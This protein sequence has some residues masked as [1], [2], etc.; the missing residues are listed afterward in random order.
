[1]WH[2]ENLHH[3]AFVSHLAVRSCSPM[4]TLTS[5]TMFAQV[6]SVLVFALEHRSVMHLLPFIVRSACFSSRPRSFPV[7]YFS[8]ELCSPLYTL[9]HSYAQILPSYVGGI[10]TF[11]TQFFD[12]EKS[13]GSKLIGPKSKFLLLQQLRR[14]AE[15]YMKTYNH[16]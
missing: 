16:V 1:M 13:G 2:L 15:L 9:T 14:I 6:I 5:F 4:C 12:P 8:L 10:H 3:F 7:S 11:K